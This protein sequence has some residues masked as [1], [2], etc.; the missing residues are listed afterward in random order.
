MKISNQTAQQFASG[1][2]VS[3]Q[4]HQGDSEYRV[5]NAATASSTPYDFVAAVRGAVEDSFLNGYYGFL[6]YTEGEDTCFRNPFK[7][8]SAGVIT[9]AE[10]PFPSDAGFL[11]VAIRAPTETARGQVTMT[12]NFNVEY[13]TLDSWTAVDIARS[14]PEDWSTA[15]MII[16]SMEQ[17][18]D[19]PIHWDRIFKTIG[20]YA[21]IGTKILKAIPHPAA[22][23]AAQ[24]AEAVGNV[25][26]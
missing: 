24:I 21:G 8:S 18:Y 22:Q 5:L 1:S 11:L 3:V 9:E 19:N 6:K 25:L 23:G 2:R 4:M 17:H 12:F 26:Q 13:L 14:L 10:S 15:N 20:R 7:F 16:S